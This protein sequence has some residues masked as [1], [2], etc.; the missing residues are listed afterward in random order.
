MKKL[1]TA[2]CFLCLVSCSSI[3]KSGGGVIDRAFTSV[4][5]DREIVLAPGR[6]FEIVLPSNPTTGY[7]WELQIDNPKVVKDI[8]KVFI[9]DRS[10]RVGVGGNTKWSL[11]AGDTGKATVD[12]MYQKSW[13]KD[14]PPTRTVT[15][16]VLVR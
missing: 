11:Q 6:H 9:A 7:T 10:K 2:V 14:T 8:S 15:F 5:A 13:E 1:L 3:S 12:F 16:T 4:D